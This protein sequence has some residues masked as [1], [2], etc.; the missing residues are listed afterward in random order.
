LRY[1]ISITVFWALHFS[2]AFGQGKYAPS[3]IRMGTNIKTIAA[4]LL[5]DQI[6]N[7]EITGDMNLRNYHLVVDLGQA[8]MNRQGVNFGYLT[9]GNYFKGGVDVNFLHVLE[10]NNSLGLGVRYARSNYSSDLSWR[11]QDNLWGAQTIERREGNISSRWFESLLH[12][13]ADTWHNLQL[14]FTFGLRFARS[15]HGAETLQVYEIP[16]YGLAE[17]V[18]LWSFNYYVYY[19]IPFKR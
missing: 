5:N 10:G 3:G 15:I 6:T 9:Q 11:L 16:G 19:Y 4:T 1:F 14:G 17:A 8:R 7:F 2:A 18:S 13:K 12:L